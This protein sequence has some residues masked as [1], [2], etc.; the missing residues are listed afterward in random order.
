MTVNQS[1]T[2]VAGLLYKK[3]QIIHGHLET[4]LMV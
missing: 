1:G 2:V 3:L 4:I